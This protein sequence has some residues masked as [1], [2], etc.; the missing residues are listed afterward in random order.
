M[1]LAAHSMT[2]DSILY[3]AVQRVFRNAVVRHLRTTLMT[4]Y[5]D[6]WLAQLQKPFK[7]EEWDRIVSSVEESAALGLI[8]R[9]CQDEFDYLSINHFYNL[10]D[11]HLTRLLPLNERPDPQ[12]LPKVRQQLLAWFREVKAVRDPM[13]HPPEDEL[14]AADA[15]RT[16]DSARRILRKLNLEE[17]DSSLQPLYE[18]LIY[19]LSTVSQSSPM[20]SIDDT[21]PPQESIVVDFVGRQSQLSQ[22]W[23]WLFSEDLKR[24]I[25]V[26]EGGKGKTSIAFRFAADAREHALGSLQLHGVFWLSAKRRRFSEGTALSITT[27]DFVDLGSALDRI[28]LDYGWAND[29]V[30]SSEAKKLT[31]LELLDT[32]PVLL[33]VDDLDSLEEARPRRQS[34][35][36]C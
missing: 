8:S 29:I 19:R 31:V 7:S 10:Y 6:D 3:E 18:E 32:L 2:T 17:A 4:E 9:Q 1:T 16:V 25:I 33:V 11:T 20:S 35:S 27:P 12:L 5:P 14:H 21:L 24:W 26:G 36:S 34:S 28:L 30:K 13:S 15:L 22:L 23:Q